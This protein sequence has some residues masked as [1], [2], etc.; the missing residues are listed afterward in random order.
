MVTLGDANLNALKWDEDNYEH[1]E[2][3]NQVREYLADTFSFQIIKEETRIGNSKDASSC[4]DHCYTDVPEKI[5]AAKVVGVG[6]SDHLGLVIK[7]LAKFPVSRPQ[8]VSR[9]CY[10]NF[11]IRS[12]LT[13]VYTSNINQGVS[14][15]NDIDEAAEVFENSFRIILDK[16]API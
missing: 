1:K 15:S 9:R 14:E 10:K 12:F 3:S 7:K 2:M 16:H 13:E 5:I 11:D 4:L 6:N 8:T